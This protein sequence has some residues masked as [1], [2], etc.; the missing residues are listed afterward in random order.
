MHRD[1]PPH[2]QLQKQSELDRHFAY[3]VVQQVQGAQCRHL[4]H[5]WG[6]RCN[7]VAVQA[8]QCEVYEL[9]NLWGDIGDG[10][11]NRTESGGQASKHS[12]SEWHARCCV[13]E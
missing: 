3:V 9:A 1:P 4:T 13:N 12:G 11:V 10:A 2:L 7:L 6:Q 5:F 8:Q